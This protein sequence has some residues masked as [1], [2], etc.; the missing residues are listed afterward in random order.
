M[1]E[2]DGRRTAK[3]IVIIN[4]HGISG[5]LKEQSVNSKKDFFRVYTTEILLLYFTVKIS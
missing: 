2:T 3:E 5:Y 1:I 4:T